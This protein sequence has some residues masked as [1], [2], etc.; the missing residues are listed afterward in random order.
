MP[1]L[2]HL[3]LLLPAALRLVLAYVRAYVYWAAAAP[4]MLRSM[5]A[6]G[7]SQ[8]ELARMRHYHYGSTYL[9]ALFEAHMGRRRTSQERAAFFWLAALAASFDDLSEGAPQHPDGGS[10]EDFGAA[11]DARGLS[12]H[13]LQRVRRGLPLSSGPTFERHLAEVF[14][15]ETSASAAGGLKPPSI[16]ALIEKSARKGGASVLLFRSLLADEA[17]PE[18]RMLWQGL[19]AL[20]QHTD[21]LFDL[22]HDVQAGISTPATHWA[23]QNDL[24]AMHHQA[25]QLAEPVLGSAGR[26]YGEAYFLVALMRVCLRHYAHLQERRGCLP[27]AERRL[28][29]VDMERWP[30]RL[31]MVA[32]LL[33]GRGA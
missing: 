17:K 24:L 31:R 8:R 28:M 20:I 11:H 7:P 6:Q 18:E 2:R 16:Q 9:A 29:V 14:E 33:T 25:R 15:A 13:L 30:N 26:A 4:A 27:L 19:G 22:W 12:L 5:G 21:D 1:R 23:A 10:P 32:E 3:L